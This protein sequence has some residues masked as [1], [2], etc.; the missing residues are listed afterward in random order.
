VSFAVTVQAAQSL[1]GSTVAG[2]GQ[3]DSTFTG[4]H[5]VEFTYIRPCETGM[6][7]SRPSEGTR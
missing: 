7:H 2:N 1:C 3:Q 5:D 4:Q 6:G